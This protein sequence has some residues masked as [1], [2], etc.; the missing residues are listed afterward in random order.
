VWVALGLTATAVFASW[1]SIA[2]RASSTARSA[3][4]SDGN[5][6]VVR[7]RKLIEFRARDRAETAPVILLFLPGALVDPVAYAPLARATAEAGFGAF[8]VPLP[9][10]GAFGGADATELYVRVDSLLDSGETDRWVI[11]GH[12]R[13][14][15]VA[16][17]IAAQRSSSLAG[18]ILVGTSHPRDV[19]LSDLPIPVA[20]IAGT[21][22]GL[23]SESEVRANAGLMPAS[24]YWTWIEGGNHSQFGW[25]GFQPGDR[26][27]TIEREAQQRMLIRVVLEFLE[28]IAAA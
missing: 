10:R 26:R 27:A 8:I 9:R 4:V 2:Y 24:T 21:R 7:S 1:S 5:V 28:R 18:L 3:L 19:D 22:D 6:E 13:G 11:A 16:S 15:V 20:K 25:Y 14:A 17:G 23:A 12:S